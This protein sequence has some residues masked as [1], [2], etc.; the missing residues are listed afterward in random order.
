M[1]QR[2]KVNLSSTNLICQHK[3]KAMRKI[4]KT[5]YAD[6]MPANSSPSDRNHTGSHV[7]VCNI[8]LARPPVS[9]KSTHYK[10][11]KISHKS[12]F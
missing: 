3:I 2:P 6:T 11:C 1:K 5:N 9:Q 7:I 8:Y 4:K 10:C 12:T